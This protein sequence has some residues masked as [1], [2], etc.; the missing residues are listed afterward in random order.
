MMQSEIKKPQSVIQVLAS[1]FELI[2]QNPWVIV[3]PIALDLLIWLGPQISI[4]PLFDR[5]LALMSSSAV[6]PPNV[7]PET[8]QNFELVKEALQAAGDSFNLVGVIATGIPSLFWIE[9]PASA[10]NRIIVLDVADG[11]TLFAVLVLL[12]LVGIWL[13]AVYFE[14][15]GRAVH[16]DVQPNTFVPRT[17]KGFANLLVLVLG[18]GVAMI[19]I[20]FPISLG[21]TV[22][23]LF[24]QELSSLLVWLVSFFFLWAMLYLAFALPA[25]F[26]SGANAL[27]AIVHSVSLFRFDFWSSMGLVIL[28]YLIRW[29]FAFVWQMFWDTPAGILFDVIA[30]AFLGGGLTAAILVFY[31]DRIKWLSQIHERMRPVQFKG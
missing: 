14:L 13:T 3:F 11:L 25:I 6:L 31:A 22:L 7:S 16:H 5:F 28:A 9:P 1:G 23:S 30:N 10:G 12:A 17:L 19:V 21:A 24:S 27:Q 2:I 8:M 29:G 26:V 15:L 4:K 18:L 20:L